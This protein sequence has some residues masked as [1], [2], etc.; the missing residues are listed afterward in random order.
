MDF[1]YDSLRWPA[2]APLP[3][4]GGGT[5]VDSAPPLLTPPHRGEGNFASA[6]QCAN[7]DYFGQNSSVG[8]SFPFAGRDHGSGCSTVRIEEPS[9]RDSPAYKY[10]TLP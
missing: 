2:G 5:I 6:P 10:G 1:V 4:S 7:A 3:S 9:I 8:V